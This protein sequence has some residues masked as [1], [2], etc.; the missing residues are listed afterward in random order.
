[1]GPKGP[2]RSTVSTGAPK[3][4]EDLWA[5]RRYTPPDNNAAWFQKIPVSQ[6]QLNRTSGAANLIPSCCAVFRAHRSNRGLKANLSS[7][8]DFCWGRGMQSWPLSHQPLGSP[9]QNQVALHWVAAA[10]R[11]LENRALSEQGVGRVH[12]V[13]LQAQALV[14]IPQALQPLLE[15]GHTF[16]LG[17]AGSQL[18][19]SVPDGIGWGS[20]RQGGSMGQVPW[21]GSVDTRTKRQGVSGDAPTPTP[22][23]GSS[24]SQQW[25][26]SSAV[27]LRR[28]CPALLAREQSPSHS[29]RPAAPGAWAL[30]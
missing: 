1:M 7:D 26:R 24:P 23:T 15:M 4:P 27:R 11:D 9:Y 8:P 2:S 14:H 12:N 19:E 17:W 18:L 21:I 29:W 22:R 6:N 5:D 13:I 28:S 25:L 3:Q 20:Q 16:S 30:Q 10:E